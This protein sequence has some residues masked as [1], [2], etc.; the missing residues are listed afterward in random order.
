MIDTV[1]LAVFIRGVDEDLNVLVG[2]KGSTT[3]VKIFEGVRNAFNKLNLKFDQSLSEIAN[4]IT[5]AM[6]G[7]HQGVIAFVLKEA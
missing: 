1:Q 6:N 4:N 3:G 7:R 5:P 2:M